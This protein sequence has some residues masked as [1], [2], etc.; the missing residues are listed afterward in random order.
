MIGKTL[1]LP[2]FS[3]LLHGSRRLT[4]RLV[5]Q[6][7]HLDGL[8]ALVARFVPR[9]LFDPTEGQRRRIF[10][11]WVTFVAFL[12][13]VLTRGSSCREA[14]RRV[15]AW[16]AATRQSIPDDSTSAYCQARERLSVAQ[17]TAAHEA[18]AGWF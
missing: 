5:Q 13:Q 3:H 2:G 11:P 7:N 4:Q 16:T 17:L 1:Y 6:G 10:T 12:G 8:A 9:E 15:Q 14:V 18:L